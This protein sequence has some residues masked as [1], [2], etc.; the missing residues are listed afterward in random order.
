METNTAKMVFLIND[1]YL[2]CYQAINNE[3]KDDIEVLKQFRDLILERIGENITSRFSELTEEDE[4]FLKNHLI[5]MNL[6]LETIINN[7]I[8]KNGLNQI[9]M[10]EKKQK[11]YQ[12]KILK[13]RESLKKRIGF[14]IN[15]LDLSIS[16]E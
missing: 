9:C 7:R 14:L 5:N 10:S 8:E 13:N 4:N 2:S 15:I 16:N 12:D 11:E 6:S 3:L 1:L